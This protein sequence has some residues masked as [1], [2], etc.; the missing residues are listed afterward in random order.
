MPFKVCRWGG[1]PTDNVGGHTADAR[2]LLERLHAI[3]GERFV[4]PSSF[5]WLHLGLGEIDEAFVWMERAAAHNDERVH[6][7]KDYSF[8]DPLS[9]DP[10]LHKLLGKPNLNS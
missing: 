3:A 2:M 6:P 5:A 8:L 9:S 7:L 10:R 1:K 4:L